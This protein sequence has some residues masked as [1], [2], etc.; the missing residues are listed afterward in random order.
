MT[1]AM[2][3]TRV[4][5]AWRRWASVAVIAALGGLAGCVVQQEQ[6]DLVGQD[7]RLTIVHTADIHSR[8]FPYN[9]VPNTFDQGYGLVPGGGPFGGI[10]RIAGEENVGVIDKVCGAEDFSFFQKEVP[11]LFWRLGC[12]PPKT[13]IRDSAPGH[14]PRFYLDEECLKLG[15]K[16]Q[17][18]LALDWLAAHS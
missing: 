11:G 14:S 7:I 16:V 5:H 13:A 18:A 10:A 1:V 6:P 3:L 2:P 9:F 15:V 4:S 8:L 12:T 17:C